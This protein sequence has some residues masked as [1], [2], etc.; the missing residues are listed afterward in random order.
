[1]YFSICSFCS[2]VVLQ[3]MQQVIAERGSAK[4]YEEP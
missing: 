3:L 4:E 1:M 2:T